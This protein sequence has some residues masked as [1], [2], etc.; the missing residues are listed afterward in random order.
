MSDSW[1]SLRLGNYPES[2]TF[3]AK[4]MQFSAYLEQAL[5]TIQTLPA[6]QR[7]ALALFCLEDLSVAEIAVAL[8]VPPG[9]IKT[10]L[11][12]RWIHPMRMR[13]GTVRD[14]LRTPHRRGPVV[15]RPD[16]SWGR[17]D[18]RL[19]RPMGSPANDRFLCFW[20]CT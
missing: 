4:T 6:A 3:A 12:F 9:T 18:G 1:V 5:S 14:R 7:S 2:Q 15:A 10:R 13:C 11:V 16:V 20:R 19:P 17:I 8:D